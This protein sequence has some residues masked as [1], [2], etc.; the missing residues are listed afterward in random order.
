M[1][2]RSYF[3]IVAVAIVFAS[4]LFVIVLR[5]SPT[6][7]NDTPDGVRQQ[8]KPTFYLT[9]SKWYVGSL[10]AGATGQ[11][12][13]YVNLVNGY[14]GV[15]CL[16]VVADPA[17]TTTIYGNCVDIS[18]AVP[19]YVSAS[20]AGTYAATIT[21]SDGSTSSSVSISVQ[22]VDFSVSAVPGSVGTYAGGSVSG[23][24]N[25]NSLNGFTGTVN[26]SIT[27]TSPNCAV[28]PSSVTLGTSASATYWC[29]EP[30]DGVYAATVNAASGSLSHS[31]PISISVYDF[32]ISGS[33]TSVTIT[34]GS[35]K[36]V[37]VVV[38]ADQQWPGY[39]VYMTT[40][41]CPSGLTCQISSTP[42]LNPGQ[43][44]TVPF[45]MTASSSSTPGNYPVT[46][47]GLVGALTHSLNV[48][49][50][51]AAPDFSI[52][53]SPTNVVAN[54][55]STGTSTIT[56]TALNGFTGT[57]SVSQNGGTPCTL[58]A[59]SVTLTTTTTYATTTLS[60]TYNASGNNSVTV[61]GS[62]SSLTH[63][64]MVTF[65]VVDFS[66]SADP[67]APAGFIA[68][69]S[70]TPTITLSSLGGFSGT[71]TLTSTTNPSVSYGPTVAFGSG[72]LSLAS[73]GQAT[74][75]ATIS[76]TAATPAGAY[77]VTITA[78]GGSLIHQAM[79]SITVQPDFTITIGAPNGVHL[80]NS[81]SGF[82]NLIFSSA[83]YTGTIQLQ[84]TVPNIAGLSASFSSSS[85][86]ITAGSSAASRITASTTKDTPTGNYALTISGTAGTVIRTSTVNIDVCDNFFSTDSNW[87]GYVFSYDCAGNAPVYQAFAQWTVASVSEPGF[88]ACLG[89]HCEFATWLGLMNMANGGTGIV[90]VVTSGV[91][92]CPPFQG[93]HSNYSVKFEFLP[94]DPVTCLGIT[95][96]ANDVV[97][98]FVTNLAIGG[99]A[100]TQY[101]I[102]IT[103]LT[104]KSKCTVVHSFAD[105]TNPLTGQPYGDMGTPHYAAF[106]AEDPS[107]GNGLSVLPKF[108]NFNIENV[109]IWSTTRDSGLA[110]LDAYGNGAFTEG[111]YHKDLMVN[112]GVQNIDISA[113][114]NRFPGIVGGDF[115]TFTVTY[116]TSKNV[117]T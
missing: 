82:S 4:L 83:G 62:S 107:F 10:N 111:F 60:C 15:V 71:V 49:V 79:I 41:G 21:G 46:A 102:T 66:I 72:T 57:V 47:T 53:A 85:I 38:K 22:V 2:T 25:L 48:S 116:L 63:G 23:S 90:Q 52:T 28:S 86:S 94:A 61:T 50:V 115:G 113:I 101:N 30:A 5:T 54:V 76:T 6:I 93:C 99:G 74:T 20:T 114:F 44:V 35:S 31:T 9:A 45:V 43:S 117:G 73:Q 106:I 100:A 7:A 56:V 14:Q 105:Y 58:S 24:I 108:T 64:A 103:N 26:L 84:V 65:Q 70:T 18:A 69:Q 96:N 12:N 55:G 89:K 80:G 104:N 33:P 67:Q 110:T 16:S 29:P 95:I 11:W 51:I 87:A 81:T 34:V 77:T 91:V 42:P 92:D 1:K 13:I 3:A 17:L 19:L 109:V 88:T 36:T 39:S 32:S 8:G 37:S 112:G 97:Q 27:S 59:T 78:T 98:A 40:T 68:G 75:G